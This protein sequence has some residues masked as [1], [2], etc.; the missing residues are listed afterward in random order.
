MYADKL[1]MAHALELRVPYLDRT[2]V[3]YSQRLDAGLKVRHGAGKW[4]HRRVCAQVLDPRILRRPKR[5]FAVGVVD[6]WFGASERGR[7]AEMVLDPESLMFGLL[8]PDG[9]RALLDEHRS[10][11]EDNH[12][13]LFSLV[14]VEEWLRSAAG[15]GPLRDPAGT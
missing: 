8:R 12:K 6:G 13:L 7:L 14:M 15:T 4:L 2:V 5:G 3:E 9:V 11:H 10:G 1:S